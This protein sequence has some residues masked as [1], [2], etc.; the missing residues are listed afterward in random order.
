MKNQIKD[1]KT[2]TIISWIVPPNSYCAH[3]LIG[4]YMN[5]TK[6]PVM[7]T[8]KIPKKKKK[9]KESHTLLT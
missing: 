9:S 4:T 1:L 7:V 3:E 8:V 2:K 5:V 6:Y